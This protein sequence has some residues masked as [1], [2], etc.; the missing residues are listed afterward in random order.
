MINFTVSGDAA[1][2]GSLRIMP[3]KIQAALVRTMRSE[4]IFLSRYVKESKL[5]GQVLKN[6]TGTLRRKVNYLVTESPGM[7]TGSVGVKLAYA[8]AHEYGIDKIVH[9]KA[10]ERMMNVAWGRPVAMPHK[11][12]VAAHSMHMH[13]PERSYLRSSFRE[14]SPRIVAALKRSVVEAPL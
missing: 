14:L 3:A 1:V 11:I 4:M 5:S 13:L 7:I 6:R 8:A 12:A 9:V 10:H 2:I